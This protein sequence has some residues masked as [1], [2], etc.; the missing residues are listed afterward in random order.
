MTLGNAAAAR[1]RLIVWCRDC[2]H[3][4]EPDATEMA[5]R[6]G[7]ETTVPDWRERLVCSQCGSRRVDFVVTGQ[8]R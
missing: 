3:R 4:V 1:V 2:R 8:R 5:E 7:A 6:Y